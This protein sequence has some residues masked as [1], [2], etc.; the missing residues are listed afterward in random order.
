MVPWLLVGWPIVGYPNSSDHLV[1]KLTA[2]LTDLPAGVALSVLVGGAV[3]APPNGQLVEGP[4]AQ[5]RGS[6]IKRGSTYSVVLDLGRGPDG[7]RQRKWHSG[8]RTKK[9]AEKARIELLARVDQ[10]AYVEPSRLTL[11]TFL[12]EQW[13]PSLTGQVRPTTLHAYRTNLERYIVPAIGNLTL[14]RLTPA[15]LN[16]VYGSLL[17]SGGKGGRPLSA[18]TVQAVHMTVRKALGDSARWGLVVRNVAEL[19]SPPRPRRAEMQTWTAA[20][21]RAFL[22]YVQAERLHALWMLAASSGMRRGELLG[23]RW[24]DVDLDRAR[25]AVRQTLVIAGREVVFSQPK[26]NR[27][28]RSIAIDPRTVEA[29]RSWR[30]A[31]LAERLAWAGA[32]ADSGL[33]FTREDGTPIHPEWLSDAFEWRIKTAGLPRI[34]FH[35]LRHTHASLG[36]AAGI[37]VKVMS[38]RLG[39]SS[40]SFTADTYQHVTPALEEQAASTVA[41]LV[42]GP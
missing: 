19:A 34:R 21:L 40:S 14:Q 4:N 3:Y 41:R 39:H 15:H 25:V 30:K 37:P 8:Y 18:R 23:L 16:A 13:L 38:E 42:F 10:G 31:Q 17:V 26:T 5:M 20:E 11:T 22:E 1:Q 33:V 12:R 32:W 27:G 2:K 29:L 24:V 28:R 35:D 6:V 36:L 9:E 7:K